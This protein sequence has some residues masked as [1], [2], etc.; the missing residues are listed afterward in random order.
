MN[1]FIKSKTKPIN[2]M[3]SNATS[4]QKLCQLMNSW[5]SGGY[6]GTK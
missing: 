3:K 4:L 5:I 1:I 6:L 2:H